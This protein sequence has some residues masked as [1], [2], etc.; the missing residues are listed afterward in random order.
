MTNNRFMLTEIRTVEK[1][2]LMVEG[3]Q[4]DVQFVNT[5]TSEVTV[6]GGKH[7]IR[8]AEVFN[9]PDWKSNLFSVSIL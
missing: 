5:I 1:V 6:D 2:I 7:S 9:V 4:V 8:V 3:T